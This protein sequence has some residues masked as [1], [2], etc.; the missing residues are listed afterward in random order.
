MKTLLA[1]LSVT[2]LLAGV[3][4]ANAGQQ[5]TSTE[6]DN[7]LNHEFTMPSAYASAREPGR[8]VS[9]PSAIDFQLQGR[10]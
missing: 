5:V 6:I 7:R 3:G 2:M 4:A 1:A 10:P 8:I 9:A